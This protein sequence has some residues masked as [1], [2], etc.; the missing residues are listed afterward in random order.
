MNN[1]NF[2]KKYDYFIAIGLGLLVSAFVFYWFG[3]F[4]V[5]ISTPLAYQGEDDFQWY[6]LSKSIHDNGWFWHNDYLGAPYGQN[7]YDFPAFFQ[8]NFENLMMKIFYYFTNSPIATVNCQFIFNFGFSATVSYLVFEVLG[9]NRFIAMVGSVLYALAP[10]IQGRGIGHLCLSAAYFVPLSILL[11]VWC[12]EEDNQYLR[13]NR[14]FFNNKKNVVTLIAIVLIANSGWGY[15]AI[16]TCFFLVVTATIKIVNTKR[17]SEA[18]TSV[19]IIGSIFLLFVLNVVPVLVYEVSHGNNLNIASR[20]ILDGELYALKISYFFIPTVNTH[21]IAILEKFKNL[22]YSSMPLVT[23]NATGYLGLA[24][25]IGFVFSLFVIMRINENGDEENRRNKFLSQLVIFAILFSTVGGFSGLISVFFHFIR[26]YCRIAIFIDFICILLFLYLLKAIFKRICKIQK[27]KIKYV[28]SVGIVCLMLIA[29]LSDLI[30]PKDTYSETFANN[31]VSYTSD[32]DFVEQV[33]ASMK[34]GD[35]IF[36]LP[37][38]SFP[39][40]GPIGN[41]GAYQLFTGY[42]YSHNLKWSFGGVKN[43]ESDQWYSYAASLGVPEMI[44]YITSEGFK[45]LY[46]DKRAYSDEEISNL[47]TEI[48]NVVQI[49]PLISENGNLIFYNLYSY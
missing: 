26:G 47:R 18:I 17:I 46:I 37:Y 20:Y 7:I 31:Y 27:N 40:S 21:G 33:E 35:M 43:R 3:F 39:E 29:C 45:G 38:D 22:Y 42:L 2:I 4:N 34:D 8:M 15:Y 12:F 10:Y 48:E 9:K 23:E 13:L 11:C 36:Q 28:V 1:A 5:G 25:I 19:K 44:E 30:P 41:M 24:G 32:K 16:F 49:E 14:S 6:F